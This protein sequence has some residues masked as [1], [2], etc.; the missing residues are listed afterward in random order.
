MAM[1]DSEFSNITEQSESSLQSM[2]VRSQIVGLL[3]WFLPVWLMPVAA[4]ATELMNQVAMNRLHDR[5]R[6]MR[7]AMHARLNEVDKSKVDKEWFDHLRVRGKT[8]D[9][10]T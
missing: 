1:E 9:G 8:S 3:T 2:V 5:I 10:L 6:E 7:E 4:A